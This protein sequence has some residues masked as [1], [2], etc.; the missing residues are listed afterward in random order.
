MLAPKITLAQDLERVGGDLGLTVRRCDG[1][2]RR[3]RTA[4]AEEEP[5]RTAA[6]AGVVALHHESAPTDG[7]GCGRRRSPPREHEGGGDFCASTGEREVEAGKG[8]ARET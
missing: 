2:W 3:L 7:G 6:A 1:R 8:A 5:L 4:T